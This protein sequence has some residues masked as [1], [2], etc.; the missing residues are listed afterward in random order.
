LFIL[1]DTAVKCRVESWRGVERGGG[2]LLIHRPRKG[3]GG[4]KENSRTFSPINCHKVRP[5][6]SY[7]PAREVT[8]G[9]SPVVFQFRRTLST[10]LFVFKRLYPVLLLLNRCSVAILYPHSQTQFLL[11]VNR[12]ERWPKQHRLDYT[13]NRLMAKNIDEIDGRQ[14]KKIFFLP[15]IDTISQIKFVFQPVDWYQ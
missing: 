4:R 9:R 15:M 12:L 1:H 10:F 5:T 14:K 2:S 6:P 7:G 13:D 8:E 11:P 3:G